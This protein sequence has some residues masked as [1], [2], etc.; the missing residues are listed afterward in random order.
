MPLQRRLPK[1]GFRNPFRR[2]FAVVNLRQIESCFAAGAVV[3]P[4]ALLARRLVRR[5]RVVKVLAVGELTKALTVKA[6][7]FSEAA[8]S[9]I[10]AAGGSAEVIS[11][12]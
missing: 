8:R 11:R 4:E 2:E 6:H 7:A 5:G 10:T 9:R 12:A 1:R 3:D